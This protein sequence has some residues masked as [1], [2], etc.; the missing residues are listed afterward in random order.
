LFR[1]VVSDTGTPHHASQHRTS[2][3]FMWEQTHK[4]GFSPRWTCTVAFFFFVLF[5]HSFFPVFRGT[6]IHPHPE[7]VR[8]SLPLNPTP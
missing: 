2:L 3:L 7:G 1:A 4:E 5:V 6:P 8:L